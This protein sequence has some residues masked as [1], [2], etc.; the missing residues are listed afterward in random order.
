MIYVSLIRLSLHLYIDSLS[1]FFVARMKNE[2]LTVRERVSPHPPGF[3]P[4]SLQGAIH[5]AMRMW[6]RD[7]QL[8]E[9]NT[10]K[11]R[12]DSASQDVYA[13]GNSSG[14][15]QRTEGGD[16]TV[17]AQNIIW[18]GAEA[19]FHVAL[20]A[21]GAAHPLLRKA[22]VASAEDACSSIESLDEPPET[23]SEEAKTQYTCRDWGVD[24]KATF[25]AIMARM[26]LVEGVKRPPILM[27]DTLQKS[28]N[29]HLEILRSSHLLLV[30]Y[31]VLECTMRCVR[32][33]LKILYEFSMSHTCDCF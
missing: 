23:G 5:V 33:S 22:C 16:S 17:E 26:P 20:D 7:H 28:S 1:M 27:M 12:N 31:T 9:S 11:G 4:G 10:Q 13:D 2:C 6:A 24:N 25:D 8:A 30:Q 19:L 21:A 32:L 15:R 3:A 29:V 18:W 14:K